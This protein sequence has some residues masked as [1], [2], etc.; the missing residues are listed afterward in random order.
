MFCKHV[1]QISAKLI[2]FHLNLP[3]KFPPHHFANN[4]FSAKFAPKISAIL[5]LNLSLKIQQ[6]VSEAMVLF[7]SAH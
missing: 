6:N 3:R 1:S 4:C 2:T 5:S 7:S